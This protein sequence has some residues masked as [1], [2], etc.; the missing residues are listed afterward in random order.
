M[1]IDKEIKI[2]RELLG[3][4]Q[5][6]LA[7]EIGTSYEVINRWESG[8]VD[9]EDYNINLVYSYAHKKKIYLN[10]IREQ[11]QKD[12]YASH[13]SIILFHGS[14]KGLD[15][16][17]DLNHAKDINDFG[18]GFYL[19]ETFEQ[20]ATYIA[21]SMSHH[22]YSFFMNIKDLKI[23]K[24]NVDTEWM[25]A[26][27]YYR[28]WMDEYKNHPIIKRIKEKVEEADI[29][30]API[31]DN[32]MFDLIDEFVNG[33]TSDLQCEHSL[34]STNLGFQYVARTETAIKH[35]HLLS[36]M[37]LC[38]SEK[39]EYVNKRLDANKVGLDKVQIARIEFKNKGK[40]IK[41]ILK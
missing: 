26:I 32:K 4:T 21:F 29:I 25:F 2:I 20:A 13:D 18:K 7:K 34:A 28:G 36:E 1:K 10:V 17:I 14:R 9:A 6:E 19:G 24:F 30:I 41:E 37:F 3:L 40:Y 27:A 33:V 31:A 23:L 35:L 38:E 22:I 16:L 15:G 8:L 11:M 5:Q 12:F 39:K